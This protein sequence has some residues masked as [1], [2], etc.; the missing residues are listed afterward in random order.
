MN[1][2]CRC[3]DRG[4]NQVSWGGSN[5]YWWKQSHFDAYFIRINISVVMKSKI[6]HCRTIIPDFIGIPLLW[7][8]NG[9]VIAVMRISTFMGEE[10]INID[11]SRSWFLPNAQKYFSGGI[12]VW[13][14]LFI[15]CDCSIL[16]TWW[17]SNLFGWGG[18]N[19]YWVEAVCLAAY[20]IR[21]S[22]SVMGMESRIHQCLTFIPDFIDIQ[23]AICLHS[24]QMRIS[25]SVAAVLFENHFPIFI[26]VLHL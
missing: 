22:I 26:M 20:L 5:Q 23:I 12:G 3:N 1:P 14:S 18:A 2:H 13:N 21:T 10:L 15:L 9:A 17:E 7:T 16:V 25:I 4:E 8:R 24:Y 11:S 19:Q 6:C